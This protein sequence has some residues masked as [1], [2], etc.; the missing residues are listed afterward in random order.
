L[1]FLLPLLLATIGA[2]A[3]GTFD[4]FSPAYGNRNASVW[5]FWS[6]YNAIV[7]AVTIFTCIELPRP[8]TEGFRV[9]EPAQLTIGPLTRRH[10]ILLL[11][12]SWAMLS[13]VAPIS[14]GAGLVLRLQNV[15]EPVNAR[16]SKIGKK[17][18]EVT[19]ETT[20]GLHDAIVR[21]LFSGRYQLR[22]ARFR[23]ADVIIAIAGRLAS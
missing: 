22:R 21:K 23:F 10:Q 3:Y 12:T 9:D 5:L 6:Y 7:I 1:R 8:K 15:S 18:F 4:V 14:L 20:P 13:G 17:T 16:V 11:S 2:V 19:F